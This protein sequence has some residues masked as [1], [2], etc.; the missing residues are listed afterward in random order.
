MNKFINEFNLEIKKKMVVE[1]NK[2]DS[3][4]DISDYEIMPKSNRSQITIFIILGIA[5]L[6][7]LIILFQ[8]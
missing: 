7:V 1:N 6:I 5:I 3:R 2:D 4:F 8:N